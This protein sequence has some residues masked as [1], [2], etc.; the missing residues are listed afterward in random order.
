MKPINSEALI[1]IYSCILW[2]TNKYLRVCDVK[3]DRNYQ[4]QWP[5]GDKFCNGQPSKTFHFHLHQRNSFRFR[6][7]CAR[8]GVFFRSWR[9]MKFSSNQKKAKKKKK[10]LW[11]R[12][13]K[14]KKGKKE[15]C[16]TFHFLFDGKSVYRVTVSVD[17][18]KTEALVQYW[19]R[20]ESTRVD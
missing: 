10:S 17:A 3:K 6:W 8:K 4:T 12:R 1:P 2:E 14:W 15:F 11:K 19:T 5:D 13:I 18:V 20:F 7:F 9:C 16:S